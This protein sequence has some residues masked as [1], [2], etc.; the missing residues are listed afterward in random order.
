MHWLA[1]PAKFWT[2]VFA[3]PDPA[4]E[5][6]GGL[7]THQAKRRFQ[8]FSKKKK[9]E[10]KNFFYEADEHRGKKGQRAQRVASQ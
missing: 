5:T 2:A 6:R 4:P 1:C 9:R 8:V 10:K 7:S 3:R